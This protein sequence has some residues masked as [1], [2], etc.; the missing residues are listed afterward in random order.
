MARKNI[1]YLPETS[2]W[3]HIQQHAKQGDIVIRVDSALTAVEKSNASLKYALPDNY[4]SRIG[5]DGSKLSA[6]IDTINDIETAKDRDEVYTEI[7]S[8]RRISRRTVG[9]CLG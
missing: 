6:L 3:S 2:R 4:F 1:F 8:R 7:L 9:E 5:L